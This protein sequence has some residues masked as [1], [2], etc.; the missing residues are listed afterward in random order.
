[1]IKDIVNAELSHLKDGLWVQT[2]LAEMEKQIENVINE[3]LILK[4]IQC[5]AVC[6]LT[7][8]FVE[9][10]DDEKLDGASLRKRLSQRYA[11]KL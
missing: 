6:Q 7:P 9:L 5:R 1:V 11:K 2:G 4:H 10:T 8:A 3:T